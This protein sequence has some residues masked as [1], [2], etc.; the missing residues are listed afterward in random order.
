[1]NSLAELRPLFV[2]AVKQTLENLSAE[3][4]IKVR[5]RLLSI[6]GSWSAPYLFSQ[7][8]FNEKN[9]EIFQDETFRDWLF[10]VRFV[11]MT[12]ATFQYGFAIHTFV[13][14]TLARSASLDMGAGQEF[15]I[16]EEDMV[17]LSAMPEQFPQEVLDYK[18]AKQLLAAN[19][20]MV[21][22]LLSIAFIPLE[23]EVLQMPGSNNNQ[24]K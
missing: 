15:D 23:H 9:D 4:A 10:N 14:D 24:N 22:I 20:W 12:N 11:F 18:G 8:H 5:A 2:D 19:N 1:M 21:A 3:A 17:K 13:L 7:D 16:S 6:I